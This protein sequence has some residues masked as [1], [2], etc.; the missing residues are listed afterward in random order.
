[1]FDR[2]GYTLDA[3]HSGAQRWCHV[4]KAS[5]SA[6]DLI[7]F[8]RAFRPGEVI[9]DR[10]RLTHKVGEGAMGMVWVAR[11]ELLDVDVAIKLMRFDARSDPTNQ[12]NRL[13]QE[14]RAAARLGHPAIVR[15]FDFGRTAEGTPFIVMELLQGESLADIM[16]REGRVDAIF[17]VRMLL[18]IVDALATVHDNGIVHRDIKPENIFIAR[19][20]YGRQH[21]KIVDF[22]VARFA[23]TGHSLTRSGAL[24]GTPDYM[25][26]EQARG[27]PEVD[28]RSDVWA[29]S[30]VL[31]EMMT[32]RLPFGDAETNYLAV[33]HSIV[34]DPVT[35]TL[36]F[37]V[38]DPQLWLILERG[39]R[40]SSDE[41]WDNIRVMGEA[42]AL[43]LYERGAREDAYGASL[44]TTW[45]R[46]GL[47]GV[48]IE[49]PS[50]P[51]GGEEPQAATSM[52]PR[53]S[54]RKPHLKAV[55]SGRPTLQAALAEVDPGAA[56][57]LPPPPGVSAVSIPAALSKG[58]APVRS[59]AKP[60]DAEVSAVTE[61]PYGERRRVPAGVLFLT[62]LGVALLVAG[63]LAWGR[64]AHLR[65]R[66]T[67]AA[68]AQS[69]NSAP[70]PDR[71]T[72]S[73]PSAG[74]QNVE[75]PVV[76]DAPSASSPPSTFPSSSAGI[77][78][79]HNGQSGVK[80]PT[81]SG[82][83]PLPSASTFDFG[84]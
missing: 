30:V 38:G 42:L 53:S 74:T 75:P 69:V 41:R 5:G 21:P 10:Y 8:V 46:A 50:I 48:L 12:Y 73:T 32:G 52:M 47:E 68:A 63:A 28:H 11:N 25:A 72:V 55:D 79:K 78:P 71:A 35:P 37:G 22:G 44:K 64:H 84:F 58:P 59:K 67:P 26:P 54:L 15:V 66:S 76:S 61:E 65:A 39:L 2:D 34:N 80:N 77:K 70:K 29:L 83:K 23:E 33:L 31:Y 19:D 13:L 81:H 40:K 18:P 62:G 82:K 49:T 60:M 14:A 3:R 24:M 4:S 56:V 1:M 6:S 16:S 51:P 43:W 27:D 57:D 20:E 45:L 36:S 7:P 9:A 17:A